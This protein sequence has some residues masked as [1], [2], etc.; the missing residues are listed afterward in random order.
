M[1]LADTAGAIIGGSSRWSARMK[2]LLPK[3][4]FISSE[5]FDKRSLDA[6]QTVCFCPNHMSHAL[7]YKAIAVAKSRNMDIGFIYSQNEHLALKEIAKVLVKA[8][9]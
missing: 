8:Q 2:E 4:V 9:G 7:Y 3:W 6:V 1:D 5:G